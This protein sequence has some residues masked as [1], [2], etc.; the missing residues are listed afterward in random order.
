MKLQNL[1]FMLILTITGCKKDNQLAVL[2]Q[3]IVF[4]SEYINYAWVYVHEGFVI[5][6]SGNIR[7]YKLP[8]IWHFADTN[9]YISAAD[10]LENIQQLNPPS[11]KVNKDTLLQNYNKLI[12]A[13]SGVLTEPK[14]EMF[15]AGGTVTSGFIYDSKLKKYKQILIR[16][17]GDVYIENQ[18]PYAKEIY[19][20]IININK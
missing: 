13:A 2:N 3:E 15:D 4:Q 14:V 20:W 9:G 11:S 10:M 19:D 16:Q 8:K 5:D 12:L 18:S 6:S 7:T 1:L 17:T